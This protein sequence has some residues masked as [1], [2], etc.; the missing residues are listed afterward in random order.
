MQMMSDITALPL[1]I[2][3]SE[4]PCSLGAAMFAATAAGIYPKVEDA[5]K[6]M[7][8]GFH[9]REYLPNPEKGEVYRQRFD[10]YKRYGL[11]VEDETILHS[12]L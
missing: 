2:I 5:M 1:R 11:F 8:N 10:R 9:H 4:N 7:G 6:C 3:R 12:E